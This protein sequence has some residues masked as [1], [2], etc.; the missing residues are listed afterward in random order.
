MTIIKEVQEIWDKLRLKNPLFP[1]RS[2]KFAAI[3]MHSVGFEI[4]QGKVIVEDYCGIGEIKEL[5]HYWNFDR[6]KRLYID[7]TASQFNIHTKKS[8]PNILTWSK[9]EQEIYH[10]LKENIEPFEVI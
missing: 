2:C 8:L 7:I 5:I 1:Y 9:G 4:V 6:K 3:E 10:I